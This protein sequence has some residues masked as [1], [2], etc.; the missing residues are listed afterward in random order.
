VETRNNIEIDDL[1]QILRL[2]EFLPSLQKKYNS[3][4]FDLESVSRIT[5]FKKK[6]YK[7]GE[8][9]GENLEIYKEVCEESLLKS[10]TEYDKEL[11][12]WNVEMRKI[13]EKYGY[14]TLREFL[15][16]YPKNWD[17]R[18]TLMFAV[19]AQKV[20]RKEKI[21]ILKLLLSG[22]P[23]FVNSYPEDWL[24]ANYARIEKLATK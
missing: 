18:P 9:F 4:Q 3:F 10:S 7:I 6:M 12:S 20:A 15:K 16:K 5:E 1:N 17:G 14:V 19:C 8:D 11:E 22:K 21:P 2:K 24:I 23:K 13:T